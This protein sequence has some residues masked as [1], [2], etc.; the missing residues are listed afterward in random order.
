M[1]N[2]YSHFHYFVMMNDDS[3]YISFT[4]KNVV[5]NDDKSFYYIHASKQ[6]SECKYANFEKRL[7][8]SIMTS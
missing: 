8:T 1:Y 2:F 6:D 7:S 4:L 3:M 5:I